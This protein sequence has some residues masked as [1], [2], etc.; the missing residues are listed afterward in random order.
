MRSRRS[1]V[2]LTIRR[3][4]VR[5]HLGIES[6]ESRQL[7][8]ASG[9]STPI[10]GLADDTA[11]AVETDSS[12]NAYVGGYVTGQG[13]FTD[14]QA[15]VAKYDS[16]GTELWNRTVMNHAGGDSWV[17]LM[18]SDSAGNLYAAGGF[19]G[20]I[21]FTSGHSLTADDTDGSTNDGFLAKYDTNGNLQWVHQ[22]SDRNGD[23]AVHEDP[24][25]GT[26]IYLSGEYNEAMTYD[27]TE[28]L[29]NALGYTA[30]YLIDVVDTG[31][32]GVVAGATQVQ[33]RGRV[34]PNGITVNS[35]GDVYLVGS[36]DE[37]GSSRNADYP[38][39]LVGDDPLVSVGRYDPLSLS[40][41][42]TYHPSGLYPWEV[43]A[44]LRK[45]RR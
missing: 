11:Y 40:S 18:A 29:P 16:T 6:L 15:F 14:S 13:G 38:M 24:V 43:V 27:G 44:I 35:S 39:A 30:A 37:G 19:S 2:L 34:R 28:I 8:S 17:G 26:H 5:S 32:S 42:Q 23:L 25:T 9:W 4:S 12:G 1:G 33:E 31:T 22:Q 3:C 45:A 20:V 41:R 10:G 7:L 36:F 21:E